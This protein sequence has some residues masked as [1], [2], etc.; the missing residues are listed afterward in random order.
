MLGHVLS[1]FSLLDFDWLLTGQPI[2]DPTL[3]ELTVGISP[4]A[5][6]ESDTPQLINVF[7]LLYLYKRTRTVV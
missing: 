6:A 2:N 5:V 1:M 4:P 3:N 7:W